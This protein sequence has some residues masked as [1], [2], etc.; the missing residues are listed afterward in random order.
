MLTPEYFNKAFNDA[1]IAGINDSI[2]P[3][4]NSFVFNPNTTI[5]S[6]LLTCYNCIIIVNIFFTSVL[7]DLLSHSTLHENKTPRNTKIK[8]YFMRALPGH[9]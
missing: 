6:L 9:W 4:P 8:L 7:L 3:T 2:M 5:A 1:K